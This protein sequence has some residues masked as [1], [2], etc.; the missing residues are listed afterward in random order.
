MKIWRDNVDKSIKD[1]LEQ[2]IKATVPF[3]SSYSQA[4]NPSQAQ[5]WVAIANISKQILDLNIK[6]NYIERALRD[7]LQRQEISQDKPAESIQK[8]EKKVETPK[9]IRKVKKKK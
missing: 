5:L 8:Q 1:H 4:K 6:L 7:S 2:Q 9:Q 3:K